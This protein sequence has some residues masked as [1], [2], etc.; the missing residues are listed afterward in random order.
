MTAFGDR[1]MHLGLNAML[2]AG[3]WAIEDK[4]L[5]P[6]QLSWFGIFWLALGAVVHVAGVIAESAR[7]GK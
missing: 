4:P 3:M 5:T 6:Q 7:G 2:I 1:I